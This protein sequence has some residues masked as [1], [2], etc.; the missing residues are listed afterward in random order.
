MKTNTKTVREV[1]YNDLDEAITEFLKSKGVNKNY[2]CVAYEEWG[3]Y[4]SHSFDVD[5]DIDEAD[6]TQIL[7]GN[8]HYQTQNI[9]NWMAEE[10]VIENGEY[11][12]SVY[13]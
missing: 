6:K 2:E 4:E 7:H 1:D 8:L 3:N 9:L 12:V 13:W 10:N 5:G 11:L